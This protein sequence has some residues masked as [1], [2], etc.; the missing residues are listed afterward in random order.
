[1]SDKGAAYLIAL[2]EAA[3]A[4]SEELEAAANIYDNG[5]DMTRS[6]TMRPI[7]KII[8]HCSATPPDMDIGMVEINAWHLDRGWSGIGY[9]WVIRR[10]G[11]L[12]RGRNEKMVG[13]H[14]Q[15]H[16]TNSIG[17]CLVG[18]KYSRPN[19]ASTYH[20]TTEQLQTLASLVTTKTHEYPGATVHG[21]N[22]FSSKGCPG[23]N[24]HDWWLLIPSEDEELS[25][26]DTM[27]QI[28]D[29]IDDQ[30]SDM[31]QMLLDMQA[32]QADAAQNTND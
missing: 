14:V 18:G 11:T 16:N 17:I 20:Y 6:I 26:I 31:R 30:L 13:A 29:A 3:S 23:F 4:S 19:D 21:H 2:A 10:D 5:Q 28:V 24:V 1:M 25:K 15:G 32:N 22:E 27:I 7:N 8:I 12:E 9:H